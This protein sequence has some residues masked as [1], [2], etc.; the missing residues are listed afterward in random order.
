MS[1]RNLKPDKIIV[2]GDELK[3]IGFCTTA[4]AKDILK[5]KHLNFGQPYF[6]APEITQGSCLTEKC[7][8]WN[9]GVILYIMLCGQ[10]PFDGTYNQI[11]EK[12]NQEGLS[13][14]DPIFEQISDQAKDLVKKLLS[15]YVNERLTA[16]QA[17]DHEWFSF[18]QNNQPQVDDQTKD[19]IKKRLIAFQ[20]SSKLIRATT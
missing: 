10:P 1:H 6:M 17:L 7:D 13:F 9:I 19:M 14:E 18:I 12:I 16:Q 5:I 8:I 4:Q 11:T 3:I 15:V 2:Q 20:N